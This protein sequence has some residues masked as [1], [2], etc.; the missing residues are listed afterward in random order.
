MDV[1]E[2]RWNLAAQRITELPNEDFGEY[3]AYITDAC[4][5]FQ[6]MMEVFAAPQEQYKK[7]NS[8]FYAELV[9]DAYETSFANPAYC[10]GQFGEEMGPC[11]SVYY[12]QFRRAI[13]AAHEKD[14]YRVLKQMELFLQLLAVL[15]EEEE[16]LRFLKENLYYF[17][18][19]YEEEN[20][21]QSVRKMLLPEES[22]FFIDILMESDF[23]DTDYLYRYG[24]YVSE[25]EIQVAKFLAAFPEEKLRQ[26]A[27][28]YTEG[29]RKGFEI[30]GIDLTKKKTVEMCY[31]LGFE[32]MMR[33]A[34]LLFR[35]MGLEP[36]IRRGAGIHS[37]SP[38]RQYGY[39]HRYDNSLYLNHA[40]VKFQLEIVKSVFEKYREEASLYAGPAVL[41]VF[42]EKPFAPV[43]KREN[44]SYTKEQE[45]LS[46]EYSQERSLILN[47][48]IPEDKRSYT[49]IAYPIPEIGE[50][51]EEIFKETVKV[52]T[53]D[54]DMY[55][56]IQQNL[57][58]AL[59]RGDYVH[60][61]G[62]GK[63]RTD[64]RIQLHKLEN[65]DRQTNFENCLADV[66]IPLGEVFTSPVLTGTE[67]LLHVTQVYLQELRYDNLEIFFHDGMV[68]DYNCSNYETA[69]ENRQ[70]IKENVLY[71]RETLPIGEFAIGTNTTAYV[72]GKKYGIDARLPILIAEK[73]G[74]HFALGDTCYSMSED[75]VLHNPDGKE[76]IAKDNEC[77]LLRE[78]DMAKA[79]FNCHT[80]ITIPYDELG[81][82]VVHTAYGEEIY[83]IRDGRFVLP[84]TEELNLVLN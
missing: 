71:N 24:E 19:D 40:Y 28:T 84:G 46:V 13:P 62:R 79:Y 48:Y 60:V 25:N 64:I 45:K 11:L 81:D 29:Y 44:P 3:Q 47:E 1:I 69:G 52:N 50:S 7:W 83:L 65:P 54:E 77:S 63:N 80:D 43:T 57:I 82:I 6:N 49:I 33:Q 56:K 72:M 9:G 68:S 23:T 61:T 74:P 41:E 27:A 31:A 32:P 67:G 18:H 10:A 59:D 2:D 5:L 37:T 22:S 14:R 30:A 73:T 76:I 53:L 26:M 35:E 39:D 66:N 55:R 16:K 42:G 38:N 78:T 21:E 17:F 12:V 4:R 8:C 15:Q 20:T 58:D 75:V 70:Y 51:F 34:V 36:V